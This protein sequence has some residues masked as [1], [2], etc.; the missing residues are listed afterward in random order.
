MATFSEWYAF[1]SQKEGFYANVSSDKGGET[2]MGVSR[3][4]YPAWVGWSIVDAEKRKNGGYLPR[5]YRINNATLEKQVAALAKAEFWDFFQADKIRSQA[6]ANMLV[7]FG[8]NSGRGTSAKAAQEVLGLFADG[9]FGPLTL[10]AIN[11][12]NED[13]LFD[14]L[15]AARLKRFE[16]IIK[17]DPSQKVNLEGW[18]ARV[19]EI[20]SPKARI[21][22][23]IAK[24][25][26]GALLVGI[27]GYYLK[28]NYL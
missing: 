22:W 6:V 12:A 18:T 3:K 17:A 28:D 1:S 25:G 10:A 14:K 8:W 21:G 15:K 16:T 24:I 9:K 27:S 2:Y 11:R 5:N 23:K 20:D 26:I 7:D 19:N 13:R 4:N